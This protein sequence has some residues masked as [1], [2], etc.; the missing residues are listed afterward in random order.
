VEGFSP[1]L[2]LVTIGG[3]KELEERL[4]VRPTSETIVNHMFAQW[5]QSHRD[6]PLLINQ[7]A[8]VHRCEN[9]VITLSFAFVCQI[10]HELKHVSI[11]WGMLC[12]ILSALL[13]MVISKTW[14]NGLPPFGY[15][16]TFPFFSISFSFLF[17]SFSLLIFECITLR[18]L[19]RLSL[20]I[21][22]FIMYCFYLMWSLFWIGHLYLNGI[23]QGL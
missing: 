8:N 1:E 16:R 10:L 3:G 15:C 6:L 11:E 12:N 2:A 22:N 9:S 17:A 14:S 4:V 5:I 7:W 18:H 13:V 23:W 21:F 20:L 19:D